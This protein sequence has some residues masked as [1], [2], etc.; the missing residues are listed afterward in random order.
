[1]TQN[2]APIF[3]FPLDLASEG[4]EV[5]L[6]GFVG[7]NRTARRLAELGLTP[8]TR[9]SVARSVRGQPV[10]I[11]VRGTRLA[12]DRT[13]AHRVQVCRPGDPDKFPCRRPGRR[14]GWRRFFSRRA[15]TDPLAD[16]DLECGRENA[17]SDI[18]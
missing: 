10:I 3:T 5:V 13:T 2:N 17:A 14:R 4:Q 16:D 11:S 6:V 12:I 7:C 18:E 8:R 9:L 1:M 15:C